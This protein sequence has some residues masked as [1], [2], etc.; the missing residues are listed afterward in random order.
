M[1][2]YDNYKGENKI[3]AFLLLTMIGIGVTVFVFLLL[4]AGGF[5]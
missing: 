3:L 1:F 2:D 4:K 5:I